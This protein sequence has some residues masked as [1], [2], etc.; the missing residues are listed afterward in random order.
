MDKI[1]LEAQIK[2][3]IGKQSDFFSKK[4]DARNPEE[5]VAIR[6]ELNRLKG[7][8]KPFYRKIKAKK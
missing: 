3:L 8:V 4:K 2:V 5:I 1:T 6:E 7:E